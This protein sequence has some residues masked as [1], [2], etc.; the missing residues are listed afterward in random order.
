MLKLG[1][2]DIE[3]SGLSFIDNHRIIE[4]AMAICELDPV[5]SNFNKIGAFN[6]R[7]NPERP[8][9]PDAQRVHGISFDDVSACPVWE[10]FA[11]KLVKVMGAVD[12]IVA[13]NGDSFD[14]PFITH[15]LVRVNLPIPNVKTIDT[16]AGARWAT[17]GGKLPT[18]EELCF[19]TETDYDKTKAHAALYD[20]ERMMECFFK[21][22]KAGFFT[23]P[24]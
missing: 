13:H 19:A 20:V 22:Y 4:C 9:D 11:P 21:A 12:I 2:L 3:T 16:C 10:D 15:E 24:Q 7:L 14:L 18:L 1:F 6:Q 17:P 5:T 8:I 23:I